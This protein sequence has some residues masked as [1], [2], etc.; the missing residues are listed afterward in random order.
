MA[1]KDYAH[2]EI[3]TKAFEGKMSILIISLKWNE[4]KM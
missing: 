2:D 4:I 1:N 3:A